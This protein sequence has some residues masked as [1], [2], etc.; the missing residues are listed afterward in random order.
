MTEV[1]FL[2]IGL[3]LNEAKLAINIY[4]NVPI[5]EILKKFNIGLNSYKTILSVIYR[6]SG[7]DRGRFNFINTIN[8]DYKSKLTDNII[9]ENLIQQYDTCSNEDE[10]NNLKYKIIKI[11][12]LL[13]YKSNIYSKGEKIIW[14]TGVNHFKIYKKAKY[15]AIYQSGSHHPRGKSVIFVPELN[16]YISITNARICKKT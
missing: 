16:K 12:K 11:R 10:L 6:K 7:V 15:E 9:L 5:E 13:L 4:N 3:T 8:K 14:S 2:S 1:Y